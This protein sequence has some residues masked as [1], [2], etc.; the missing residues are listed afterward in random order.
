MAT[1]DDCDGREARLQQLGST[2]LDLRTR[3]GGNRVFRFGPDI[4]ALLPGCADFLGHGWLLRLRPLPV[5]ANRRGPSSQNPGFAAGTGKGGGRG[6]GPG[7][8]STA[9]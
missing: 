9:R 8:P 4:S 5:F 6:R 2:P 3:G 1:D 7:Y